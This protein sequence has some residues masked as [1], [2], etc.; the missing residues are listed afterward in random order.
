MDRIAH[1][2]AHIQPLGTAFEIPAAAFQQPY[3]GPIT[4]QPAGD[5]DPCR[6]CT[7]DADIGIDLL[8]AGEFPRI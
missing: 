3:A 6:P 2:L 4:D 8:V 5:A 7:D 1:A